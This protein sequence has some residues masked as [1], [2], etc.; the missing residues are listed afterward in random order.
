LLRRHPWEAGRLAGTHLA[1]EGESDERE[2]KRKM[3]ENE[4]K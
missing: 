3:T 4:G 2:R 1:G